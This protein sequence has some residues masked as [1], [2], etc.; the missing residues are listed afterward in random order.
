MNFWTYQY[1]QLPRLINGT[2]PRA[3]GWAIAAACAIVVSAGGSQVVAQSDGSGQPDRQNRQQMQERR[4]GPERGGQADGQR[5]GRRGGGRQGGAMGGNWWQSRTRMD[6]S[7]IFEMSAELG[8]DDGQIAL[9]S[10]MFDSFDQAYQQQ[11]DDAKAKAESFRG[12]MGNR[13]MWSD[14]EAR[15]TMMTRMMT[16]GTEGRN[17]AT[18]L[19][20]TFLN[21]VR[22]TV[23]SDSQKSGWVN[24]ERA[25]RRRATLDQGSRL[26]GEGVDL[27]KVIE[28]MELSGADRDRITPI[29]N[30]Y[31]QELDVALID[32]DVYVDKVMNNI[33]DVMSG[34]SATDADAIFTKG[35]E[36]RLA[37]R[38]L[39]ANYAE[40]VAAQLSPANQTKMMDTFHRTAHPRV[41]RDTEVEGYLDDLRNNGVLDN[42]QLTKIVAV[43]ANYQSRL[44]DVNQQ[45]VHAESEQEVTRQKRMFEGMQMM[46]QGGDGSEMRGR[47]MQMMR[48]RT[49][50][51]DSAP[52]AVDLLRSERN[53]IETAALDSIAGILT[54]EQVGEYPRPTPE[55]DR[56]TRSAEREERMQRW[57]QR[58]QDRERERGDGA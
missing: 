58:M 13:E 10:A 42:T 46:M 17:E 15:R 33:S 26:A 40:M 30:N 41:Y 6:T 37:L 29:L 32:R 23:L 31:A 21:S 28:D 47:M 56:A 20:R 14:P 8:L 18:E 43:E 45:L 34:N 11:I 44:R 19:E 1:Q 51:G 27:F 38:S 57:Q 52:S 5:G 25:R 16:M 36:K 53:S 54:V 3:R 50:G 4:G 55:E 7:E 12:E 49:G 39:H 24:Y 2:T 35:N 9:V 48:D 22:D